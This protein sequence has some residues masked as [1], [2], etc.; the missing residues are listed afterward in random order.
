M[1]TLDKS[2]H[3]KS[4]DDFF[5][6]FLREPHTVMFL[7]RFSKSLYLV[8]MSERPNLFNLLLTCFTFSQ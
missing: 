8:R 6:V 5:V 4:A 2:T 3:N 1:K 7:F